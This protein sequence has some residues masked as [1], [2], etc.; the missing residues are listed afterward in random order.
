MFIH[1]D[2]IPRRWK[3]QWHRLSVQD[4]SSQQLINHAP[5]VLLK[6]LCSHT[7]LFSKWSLKTDIFMHK[8]TH[9]V[10]INSTSDL[11]GYL[12]DRFTPLFIY[13]HIKTH[14][15]KYIFLKLKNIYLNIYIYIYRQVL[16]KY[17]Y[18]FFLFQNLTVN[19]ESSLHK[20][21]E[22][23]YLKPFKKWNGDIKLK[24]LLWKVLHFFIFISTSWMCLE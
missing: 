17:I 9:N 13:T 16:K 3:L 24:H 23:I 15:Y 12:C 4:N 18:I 11:V 5:C 10:I 2:F 1:S 20:T 21:W 7:P 8:N 6:C 14:I 22:S 19:Q